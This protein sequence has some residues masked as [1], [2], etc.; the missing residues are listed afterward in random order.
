[1]DQSTYDPCLQINNTL[2]LADETFIKV[3]RNKLRKAKFV[4]KERTVNT[5]LGAYIASIYQLEA[6]FNLSFT[7][8]LFIAC[9]EVLVKAYN[10]ISVG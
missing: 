8:Q 4:A 7:T 10:S 2:F 9:Q 3:E 6:L 1:M 5:P